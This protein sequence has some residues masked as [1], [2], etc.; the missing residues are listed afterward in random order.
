MFFYPVLTG[1][2]QFIGQVL[3][4]CQEI[5][6]VDELANRMNLSL[7]TFNRKFQSS[8]NISP[9]KW[10]IKKKTEKVY[11]AIIESES[12]LKQ[13][14]DEVGFSSLSQMIDYCKKHIGMT[15]GE[16]RK[17]RKSIPDMN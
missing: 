17:Q 4:L 2:Y 12:P 9:Y 15:P 3:S 11:N 8:F 5:N 1:E 6:T 14:A 10:M 13:V 7:S 16:I